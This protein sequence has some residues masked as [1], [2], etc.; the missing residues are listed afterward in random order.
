[1]VML[2][3]KKLGAKLPD[4]HF[5]RHLYAVMFWDFIALI[6]NHK[7]GHIQENNCL[8]SVYYFYL[9]LFSCNCVSFYAFSYKLS[10]NNRFCAIVLTICCHIPHSWLILIFLFP[11]F[12]YSE[13][14][15][16]RFSA[17]YQSR[18]LFTA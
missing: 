1:M 12:S 15:L 6:R 3:S 8:D 10:R 16:L 11:S 5:N 7:K 13:L 9:S 18:R 4:K 17:S 2:I 14:P